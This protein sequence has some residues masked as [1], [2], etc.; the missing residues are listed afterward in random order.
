VF[1]I[2]IMLDLAITPFL[3]T[4]V[5]T[6]LCL[7]YAWTLARQVPELVLGSSAF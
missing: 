7:C 5:Q 3:M 6:H 1:F 2:G 4:M